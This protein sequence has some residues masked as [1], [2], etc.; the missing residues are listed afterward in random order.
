MMTGLEG[1]ADIFPIYI[2]DD[3]TDE[4]AFKVIHILF[5]FLYGYHLLIYPLPFDSLLVHTLFG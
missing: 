5:V 2:G 3:R 4:D 1:R